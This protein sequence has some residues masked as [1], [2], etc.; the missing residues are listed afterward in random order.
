MVMLVMLNVVFPALVR[1]VVWGELDWP[2]STVPNRK[3]AG[4]SFTVPTV[5]VIE[6]LTVA[7]ASAT[8][9]AM[10]NTG[11]LGTVAGAV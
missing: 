11:S 7:A 3:L 8:E 10:I 5:I 1:V 6:V 9:V 4:A 2:T